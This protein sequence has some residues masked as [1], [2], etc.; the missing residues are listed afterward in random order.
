[1]RTSKAMSCSFLGTIYRRLGSITD[2]VGYSNQIT[3]TVERP[4]RGGYF[5]FANARFGRGTAGRLSRR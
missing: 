2:A 3:A 5:G 4:L 1:M